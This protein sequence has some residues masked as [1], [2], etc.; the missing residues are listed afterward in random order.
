M[1]RTIVTAA[2]LALAAYGCGGGDTSTPDPATSATPGATTP[3]G[4]P[5][6]TSEAP[7]SASEAPTASEAA[8][9][10]APVAEGT[11]GGSFSVDGRTFEV[12]EVLDCTVGNEG[13]PGDRQFVGL[14]ADGRGRMTVS[15]FDGEA[16]AG[17]NTVGFDLDADDGTVAETTWDS[18]YAGSDGA[19]EIQLLDDGAEGTA[20]VGSLGP[21]SSDGTTVASWSFRC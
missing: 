5:T 21:E 14:T 8:A 2:V 20:D 15:H 6:P 10:A 7:P 13:A 19:F 11:S 3:A 18:T 12:V 4:S 17:M 1:R 9:T 16:F